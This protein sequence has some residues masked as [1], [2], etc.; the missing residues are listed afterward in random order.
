MLARGKENARAKKSGVVSWILFY[1][2]RAMIGGCESGEKNMTE[3]R[4]VTSALVKRS[5]ETKGVFG[6]TEDSSGSRMSTYGDL[7]STSERL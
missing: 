6:T 4:T 5:K 7:S 2:R 1:P 3:H